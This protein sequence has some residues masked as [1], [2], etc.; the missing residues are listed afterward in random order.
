MC[1]APFPTT[2]ARH[3]CLGSPCY[4]ESGMSLAQASLHVVL[5]D[6]ECP[7]C[8]R[9]VRWLERLDWLHRLDCR[10][11]PPPEEFSTTYPALDYSAC[12]GELHLL[13]PDGRVLRGFYA[14][15]HLA[16]LLPLLWPLLPLL[17][18]PGVD[19]VGSMVYRRVAAKRYWL[20]A[21]CPGGTCDHRVGGRP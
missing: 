20:L 10:P 3:V 6:G 14:F 11:I 12:Q 8:I 13:L 4:L 19:R 15:R 21:T 7:F 18:F 2:G 16:R 1:L 17:H 5:Y 9:S